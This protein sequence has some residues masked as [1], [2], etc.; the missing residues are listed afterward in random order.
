MKQDFLR[1]NKQSIRTG[2]SKVTRIFFATDMHGSETTF[3]KFINS[4]KFYK[5]DV[6][7]LGGDL[8]GKMIISIIEQPDNTYTANFLGNDYVLKDRES[9]NEMEK[10][11]RKF[12]YYPYYT[13]PREMEELTASKARVSELMLRLMSERL[14]EWMRLAEERLKDTGIK[15]YV[16]GGNDDPLVVEQ[17]LNSSN[18]VVNPQDRVVEIDGD[19]EMISSGLSNPTPWKTAREVTEERLGDTIRKMMQQVKDSK[20]CIFN[21][22]VPPIDSELDTC[23]KLDATVYPPKPISQGGQTLMYGAGSS[24]VRHA[25]EEYQ[26]LLGLF[27]HIHESR[28]ATKIGRTLCIN[29]GSEYSEGVLRGA[30]VTLSRDAI[31]AYQLTSG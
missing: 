16:T 17:I 27:G 9:A 19:H 12:G 26:P 5:V 11:I 14:E 7:I 28:G 22:H 21:L 29:P 2:A 25:I 15:I 23:P 6:L 24:S 31:K 13:N 18:Y 30:I 4:G 1:S 3:K 10:R 20:N 8:T